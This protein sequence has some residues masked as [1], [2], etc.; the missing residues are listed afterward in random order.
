MRTVS[1]LFDIFRDHHM[2]NTFRTAEKRCE[3]I[4]KMLTANVARRIAVR[5]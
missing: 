3:I 4:E 5:I 1:S 2:H